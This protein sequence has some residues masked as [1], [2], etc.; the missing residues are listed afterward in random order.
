MQ[1]VGGYTTHGAAVAIPPS[2]YTYSDTG[3]F[4][5]TDG[6]ASFYQ[7]PESIPGQLTSPQELGTF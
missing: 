3:M 6:T 5:D 1:M 2:D 7:S 4:E